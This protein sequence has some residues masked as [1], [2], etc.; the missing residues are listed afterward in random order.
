MK[1]KKTDKK[2]KT[3]RTELDF[4]KNSLKS[5]KVC[6]VIFIILTINYVIVK[7][8]SYAGVAALAALA[9]G[10]LIFVYNKKVDELNEK[11]K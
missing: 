9:F 2:K 3:P 6:L 7:E 5:Y 8:Y 11:G 1:N 10:S 4:A